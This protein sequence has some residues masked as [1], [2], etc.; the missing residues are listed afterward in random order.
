LSA[1]CPIT[2]EDIKTEI[3]QKRRANLFV[4]VVEAHETVRCGQVKI[5]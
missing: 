4:I 2:R 5:V 3:E 1:A